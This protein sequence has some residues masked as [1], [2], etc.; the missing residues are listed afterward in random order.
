MLSQ[1]NKTKEML[2]SYCQ[3]VSIDMSLTEES[4]SE[5]IS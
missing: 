2:E 1:A 5:K 4:V 3:V